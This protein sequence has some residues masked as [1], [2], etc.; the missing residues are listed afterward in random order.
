M[1]ELPEVEAMRRYFDRTSLGREV[2]KVSVPDGRVLEGVSAQ[3]LGRGLKGSSFTDTG[4]RAKYLLAHADN[5]ATL[6]LH[7]GMTGDLR[8]L[9][10]GEPAP[11]YDR[12]VL[13]FEGGSRLHF[14]DQR[15]FGKVAL[16]RDVADHEIPDIARLGPEPLG[17]GFTLALFEQAAGRRRTTIHQL[18]MDQRFVAGIGNLFSDEI[19]FQAGIRP[20]RVTSGLS[21]E[22]IGRLYDRTRCALRRALELNADLEAHADVFLIPNRGRGGR[23]P[24]S[25]DALSKKTIGGRTS[26]YC[27]ACQK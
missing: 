15:L 25:G 9:E 16:F 20:D 17:K 26:Y 13:H 8:F 10:K 21:D 22:E 11:R 2:R 7:F 24:R 27:P 3:A 4:R 18:L 5:G 1:P 14:T 6:L 23:C 12:V 19:C